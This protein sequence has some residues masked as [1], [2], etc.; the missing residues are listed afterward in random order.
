M[1]RRVLHPHYSPSLPDWPL[2]AI[3]LEPFGR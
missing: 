1:L 2:D 3:G